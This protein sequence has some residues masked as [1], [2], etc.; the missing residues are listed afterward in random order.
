MFVTERFT[1][2]PF[3]K[4]TIRSMTPEFGFG[5]FGALVYF[6]TYSRLKLDGSQ[7]TW[8]DTVI[9]VIEGVMSIEKDWCAKNR[10]KW[11]ETER[12]QY[13]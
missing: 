12:Q 1:L 13:A 6:R 7:E 5:G 2:S 8:A 10:L 4:R 11:D 9:R 3:T